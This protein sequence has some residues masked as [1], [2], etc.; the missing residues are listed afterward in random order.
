MLRLDHIPDEVFVFHD[1]QED[2]MYKY[3][4]PNQRSM[5]IKLGLMAGRRAAA[6]YAG[7]D[8]CLLM[9]TDGVLLRRIAGPSPDL[10]HAQICYDGRC[11]HVDLFVDTAHRICET[12]AR[13]GH[14]LEQSLIERIF[15]AHEFY[16]WLEYSGRIPLAEEQ[17]PLRLRMLGGLFHRQVLVRRTSE[18]AAFAFSKEFCAMTIHPKAM[19]YLLLCE[20][21][22]SSPQARFQTLAHEYQQACL[23]L[24]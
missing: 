12:M 21:E 3:I 17:E 10:M 16:H 22:R 1:L 5:Y 14:P 2:L 18:I 7:Q 24:V 6:D 20:M 11:R 9:Q 23:G 13:S 8:I 15:L 4:P 19:D